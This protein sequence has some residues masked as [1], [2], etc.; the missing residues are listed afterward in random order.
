VDAVVVVVDTDT[1]DWRAFLAE[2]LAVANECEPR[3]NNIMFRLAIEE[4]EAWYFGD[5]AAIQAA[6]PQARQDILNR[7]HQDSVCGTWEMLAD[8]VYPGG[9]RAIK[10]RGFPASGDA[11]HE[12]AQKITPHM[13]VE[14][15]SSPS[16][17]KF[18]EGM[19]R[20]AGVIPQS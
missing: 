18:V 17:L 14:A 1:R 9:S 20:L 2:L 8:A 7:Y 16:F 5:R 3:P 10:K 19:R 12:W 4:M 11:K 6:Y 13:D 15:N